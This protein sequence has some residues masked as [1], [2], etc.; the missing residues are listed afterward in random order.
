M[1]GEDCVKHNL[2]T[3]GQRRDGSLKCT[4]SLRL[5]PCGQ[6]NGTNPL[7]CGTGYEAP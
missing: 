5:A 2:V 1:L 3:G 6:K 4:L 7:G